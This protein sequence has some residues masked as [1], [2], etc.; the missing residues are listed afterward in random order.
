MKSLRDIFNAW[1]T[2][3]VVTDTFYIES[4]VCRNANYCGEHK[5]ITYANSWKLFGCG[6]GGGLG[7]SQG[8]HFELTEVSPASQE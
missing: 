1:N 8:L 4:K 3:S 2:S 6:I 7:H 5:K